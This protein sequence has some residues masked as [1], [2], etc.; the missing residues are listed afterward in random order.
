MTAGC[1]R[2]EAGWEDA[3]RENSIAAYEQYLESFPAG[4]HAGDAR[5]KILE[6]REQEAWARANRL[7]TPEAWQRYL[8]EWPEGR[9]AALARRQLAAFM[10]PA[11]PAAPSAPPDQGGFAVQ[12]GAYS[13]EASARAALD[14]LVRAHSSELAG[15]RAR[16]LE[17][18][19]PE[20]ALWRL[21]AGP[22]DEASARK[23][24]DKLKSQGADCMPVAELS[25]GQA[26]P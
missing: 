3:A 17:P 6:L 25:A 7:R 12:L 8:G 19:E 1:S 22:L 13:S 16:V 15:L 5:A 11:A 10:P 14:R 23:L 26:P 9:H 4:A 24:C 20:R 2:Q 18:L 21:R